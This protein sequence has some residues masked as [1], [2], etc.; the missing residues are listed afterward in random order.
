ML[1]SRKWLQKHIEGELP[2]VEVIAERLTM[3]AFE[4]ESIGNDDV[5]DVKILPDRAHYALCHRGV[6]SDVALATGLKR[7]EEKKSQLTKSG[8]NIEIDIE[9]P[10]LC[11][12]YMSAIVRGVKV[13]P[14]PE[15][16]REALEA[17]GQRSINNIVDAANYVMFDVGQP[18]HAFDLA[19][20]KSLPGTET[21][22][23]SKFKIAIQKLKTGE[24]FKALDEKEY[25]LK[26]DTLV[27]ADEVSGK[28]LAIAGVK[29]GIEAAV[30]ND[31]ADLLLE[32]ANF[33]GVVVRKAG[34]GLGLVTDAQKRFENEI[35]PELA[36][37]GLGNLIDLILEVAGGKV[38]TVADVYPRPEK[39]YISGVSLSE[40][41]NV[42]GTKMKSEEV[43]N[44]LDRTS[45]H[46]EKVKPIEVLKNSYEQLVGK[47]Y[48]NPTSMRFDSPEEF[49]C[50]SLI[51]Y[52]YSLA[53]I[54]M[55]SLTV[56]KLVYCNPVS[57]DEI[58]F[59]DLVFSN[60]EE[61]R[62]FYETMEW[63]PGTRVE[64][65]V[66][67][68]GMYLGDGMIIHSTRKKG[69]V[70][71]EKLQGSESFKKIVGIGRLPTSLE[72]ERYVISIPHERLD[73]RVKEDLIEE[74]GR[75]YGYEHVE[76]KMPQNV[77]VSMSNQNYVWTEILRSK[78]VETGYSEV[79]TYGLR[80]SGVTELEN[81]LSSDKAYLRSDLKSGLLQALESNKKN[82]DL[83]GQKEIKI[84]EIGNVFTKN[85]EE[86]HVAFVNEKETIEMTLLEAV[87]HMK[88]EEEKE[89]PKYTISKNKFK[90]ISPYPFMVRDIAVWLPD[91]NSPEELLEVIKA[92]SGELLVGEPRKFDQ[93]SKDGRTSYA[94]RMIYQSMDRTLTIEEV[95]Q[96]MQKITD[97]L[98]A[99]EGWKVR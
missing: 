14:S 69:G 37:Q 25:E 17:I 43:E 65:G 22:E 63:M 33:D 53:G 66:D 6:A 10:K 71:I 26:P 82:K 67:H 15:W 55:P 29:G 59:G 54:R 38:E 41:N 81:P 74:I 27:I 78:F 51:S 73:L 23:N 5:F 88:I 1:V 48:K 85:G 94:Y 60:S 62:I 96:I 45:W 91:T 89:L 42:L 47:K 50:S 83:L 36:E 7:K 52:I 32:S 68:V 13:G 16:L 49:S 12:R 79:Y 2:A 95:N 35:T 87:K 80:D 19:K 77:S 72:V 58:A 40:I 56:D 30:T 18:L 8:D 90:P 97:K 9:D 99:K 39:Q 11:R 84:F 24:K 34:R 75:I 4:I 21:G 31:T 98:N 44:I 93:F 28:T 3:T 70:L 61:G 86:T 20:L 64:A 92:E 46:W 76:E 57:M